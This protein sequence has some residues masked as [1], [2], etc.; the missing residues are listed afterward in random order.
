VTAGANEKTAKASYDNNE[1]SSWTNDG[2]LNTAWITYELAEKSKVDE[3][4]LK[5]NGFRT[6]Q[7]PILILVDGK[8]VFKGLTDISLG[9]INIKCIPTT[10]KKVKIILADQSLT[11]DKKQ[12]AEM[13]GK[14]LDDGNS[15]N[16]N[17]KGSL[18]IIEVEIYKTLK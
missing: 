4:V 9:Y 11:D 10:G 3:V 13:N 17:S 1:L 6:K 14:N 12:M 18:G 15:T 8:E 2:K 7:Y 5:L 16:L